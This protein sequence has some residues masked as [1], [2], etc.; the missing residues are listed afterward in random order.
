MNMKMQKLKW[1]MG[2]VAAAILSSTANATIVFSDDFNDGFAV[3]DAAWDGVTAAPGLYTPDYVTSNAFCGGSGVSC[4]DMDGSG[5][6][7]LADIKTASGT[8]LGVGDYTFSYDYGHNR[9][10]TAQTG[11]ANTLF[12]EILDGTIVL[13]SGDTTTGPAADHTYASGGGTFTLSTAVSGAKIRFYQTG[14][15]G[16]GLDDGGTILDNVLLSVPAPGSLALLGLG[17]LGL[18]MRNR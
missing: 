6:G 16:E 2:V 7:S 8:D 18:R 17:L 9:G 11:N 13:A 15:G 10:S 1:A 5:A 3:F 12:W 14:I 4:L